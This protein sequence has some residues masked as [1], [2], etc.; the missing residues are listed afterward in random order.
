V[1]L[2]I[3]KGK[4]P[5]PVEG[6]RSAVIPD[7]LIGDSLGIANGENLLIIKLSDLV[8]FVNQQEAQ[9]QQEASTCPV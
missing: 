4:L 8:E 2:K 3:S 1:K 7:T 6:T 9:E 5:Q